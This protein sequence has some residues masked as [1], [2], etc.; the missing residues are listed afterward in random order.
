MKRTFYDNS[1][2]MKY[3][4]LCQNL[5]LA[6][7]EILG[8]PCAAMTGKKRPWLLKRFFC[9]DGAHSGTFV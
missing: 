3:F 4:A 8:A 1:E 6:E 2:C 7:G 9:F 5:Y